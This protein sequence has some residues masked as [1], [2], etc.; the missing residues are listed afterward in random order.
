MNLGPWEIGAIVAVAV[1]IFG[2][3]KLPKLGKSAA[4]F[5]KNFKSGMNEIKKESDEVK[6]KLKI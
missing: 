2:P 3:S 6:K 1:L 4:E 5:L